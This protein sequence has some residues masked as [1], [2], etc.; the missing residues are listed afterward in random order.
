[1]P[2]FLKSLKKHFGLKT[3]K[4][5][6]Y[7]KKKEIKEKKNKETKKK[8]NKNKN[9]KKKPIILK[10]KKNLYNISNKESVNL[11]KKIK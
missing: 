8:T 11:I 5:K 9:I 10:H 6:K 1:M 3:R 7:N 2:V 4:N